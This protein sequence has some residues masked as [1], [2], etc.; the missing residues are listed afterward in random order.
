MAV[1]Y[2]CELTALLDQLREVTC[3][4]DRPT[5][6]STP[7]A[8]QPTVGLVDSS[9]RAPPRAGVSQRGIM[10]LVVSTDRRQRA[11]RSRQ[12]GV[13]RSTARLQTTTPSEV[14]RVLAGED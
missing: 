11:S 9:V 14:H 4:L 5:H 2:D 3:F 10:Q 12:V 8:A 7:N 13:V 6:V 1:L